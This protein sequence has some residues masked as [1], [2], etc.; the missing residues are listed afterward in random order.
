MANRNSKA[1]E[2]ADGSKEAIGNL[3]ELN[4]GT[5][6]NSR[7]LVTEADTD[8]TAK[9]YNE[10]KEAAR[11]LT[12]EIAY[13]L[14]RRNFWYLL[15]QTWWI[16][17]LIHLDESTLS[18]AST[19]G[20]FDDV[21]MTKKQYN[22][23]FV[24]YY[25]G[26]LHFITGSLF[27]WALLVG[28]HPAVKT[29]QQLM[30]V[31]F[32]LGLTASQIIPSTTVLHQSFF[33]PKSSPW[34]QLL[35]WSAGSVANVLLTMVAYKLIID[36][37]NGVLVAGIASW[38]WMNIM[39]AIIT[40]VIFAPLV[41]FLPNSPVDAKWLNTE[42]K[43]HTIAVIRDTHSGIANSSFKWSQVQ[44]CFADIKSWMFFFHMFWNEIPNNTSQQ[45]PLIIPL[46][47]SVLVLIT[48]AMMY[49]TKLGTGYVCAISYLPCTI[50]GIIELTAPWSNKVA[51]VVGTQIS[52]FKPSY[53]LGL[54]WAGTTTTGYTKKMCLMTTCVIAAAA[55]NMIAP[56]FW[57]EKYQPRYRLPW[58]FMTAAWVICP[59][60]CLL[61]RFY[62]KRENDRRD[63]LMAE[64]QS[65]ESEA[66]KELLAIFGEDHEVLKIHEADLDLT[67]RENLKFRYPL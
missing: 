67:D 57:Q 65:A 38:K 55:S 58:A 25:T 64:Q 20:I 47:G 10:H 61:I 8:N 17:F 40:F 45:L 26:Y 46:W 14:T 16:S 33:P 11:P 56:E 7:V 2:F 36:E 49:G 37:G 52:S 24:L 63:K 15:C 30:A 9:F 1:G 39:C 5:N 4:T 42:Q 23:L 21:N 51:L 28:V 35:W 44:E 19:M 53:L 50:G 18:Q 34:V 43:V 12:P 62:L 22:D 29:G 3:P 48:A 60:M 66:D 54:T 31:R 59:L 27:I 6:T 32:L 41:I 13:A